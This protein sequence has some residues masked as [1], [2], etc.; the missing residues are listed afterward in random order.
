VVAD[1]FRT[2]LAKQCNEKKFHIA[3]YKEKKKRPI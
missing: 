2:V 3:S 1:D